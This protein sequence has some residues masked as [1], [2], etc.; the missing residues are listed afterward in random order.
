MAGRRPRHGGISRQELQ[1]EFFA[2]YH[3]DGQ[4]QAQWGAGAYDADGGYGHNGYVMGYHDGYAYFPQFTSSPSSSATAV[5]TTTVTTPT[6]TTTLA[7]DQRRSSQ[8]TTVRSN[9]SGQRLPWRD[10]ASWRNDEGGIVATTVPATEDSRSYPGASIDSVLTGSDEDYFAQQQHEQDD[11]DDDDDVQSRDTLR[12]RREV[13][14]EVNQEQ[15]RD[16]YALPDEETS[17]TAN[18]RGSRPRG[19]AS[20]QRRRRHHHRFFLDP[21]SS[22]TPGTGAPS[23]PDDDF[24][25]EYQYAIMRARRFRASVHAPDDDKDNRDDILAKRMTSRP[26]GRTFTWPVLCCVLIGGPIL[27][28]IGNLPPSGGS[29]S[30]SGSRT[31][32]DN[33]VTPVNETVVPAA[34][35]PTLAGTL[36]PTSVPTRSP[37][38]VPTQVPVLDNVTLPPVITEQNATERAPTAS[39]TTTRAVVSVDFSTALTNTSNE[40]S[41]STGSILALYAAHLEKSVTVEIQLPVLAND[42]DDYGNGNIFDHDDF[43]DTHGW[44]LYTSTDYVP[45]GM[46][47]TANA[48]ESW[49]LVNLTEIIT[50]YSSANSTMVSL[51]VSQDTTIALCGKVSKDVDGVELDDDL[52]I[53][54]GKNETKADQDSMIVM[55]ASYHIFPFVSN[56]NVTELVSAP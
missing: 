44:S 37:T 54:E 5:A 47:C 51:P 17:W 45:L 34:A 43:V 25:D 32:D 38:L 4:D 31:L 52:V 36:A 48:T 12:E 30:G 13:S 16:Q 14:Y 33:P 50:S 49:T 9:T 29:G 46:A 24:K 26:A 10:G 22:L 53:M 42:D 15:Q 1:D 19:G 55:A 41:L 2:D 56:L 23:N 7:R 18:S 3:D 28:V 35:P 20:H 8:V 39:P 11:D 21:G 27:V 40:T 6:G